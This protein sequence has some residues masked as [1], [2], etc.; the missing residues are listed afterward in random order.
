[1]SQPHRVGLVGTGGIA[2]AHLRGYRSVVGDRAVVTAACDP[3]AEV[4]DRFCDEYG[5]AHRFPDAA[6]MV[7]SGEVDVAVLLTPP[8]VREEVIAPALANG[9]HLLVEKPFA[10]SAAA[11][12]DFV[13]RAEQSGIQLAVSQNFR[14]FPEHEWMKGRLAG[15]DLGGLRFVEHRSFQNRP[16]PPGVWRAEESRLEMAIFSVHLI[17]RIQWMAAAVAPES[18]AA[19]TRRDPASGLA[20][21]QFSSLIIQFSGGVVGQM[22]SNWMS[23][24][25]PTNELRT[26]LDRGSVAVRREQPMSG[27]ARGWAQVE[28]EALTEVDFPE[29]SQDPHAPRTYGHSLRELLDAIDEKRE[30]RH[31]GR[32]NLRTMAI[33]DTAYLSAARGGALVTVDEVLSGYALAS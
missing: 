22:T 8:K 30:P 14:W 13:R 15:G 12:V 32:D 21:E 31:S 19:V 33:M 18:V 28:G 24:T 23:K 7:A 26:D 25:L 20:G 1:M 16:Q 4:L 3:R 17:D 6:A 10:E 29:S 9:V 27:P 11:A 5:V 2:H